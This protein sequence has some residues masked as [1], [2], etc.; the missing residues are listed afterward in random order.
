MGNALKNFKIN[1]E[2]AR[3][4][5]ELVDLKDSLRDKVSFLVGLLPPDPPQ[6]PGLPSGPKSYY[7]GTLKPSLDDYVKLTDEVCYEQSLVF[8]VTSMEAYL[9][10]KYSE[11]NPGDNTPYNFQRADKIKEAFEKVGVNVFSNDNK[12]KDIGFILQLRHVIVHR[13]GII[14][15]ELN[16]KC[17]K[18]NLWGNTFT[19]DLNHYKVGTKTNQLLNK[20]YVENVHGVIKQF[21]EGIENNKVTL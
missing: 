15:N 8:A 19:H 5:K 9:Q 12:R 16:Q 1:I 18:F 6:L 4:L 17:T 21:V 2:K 20:E 13:A 7:F 14:D 10:D 11:L 3:R